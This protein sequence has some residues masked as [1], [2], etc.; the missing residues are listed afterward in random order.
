MKYGT[1]SIQKGRNMRS[2]A[3]KMSHGITVGTPEA[4][5]GANYTLRTLFRGSIWIHF[6]CKNRST[7]INEITMKNK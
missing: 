5:Q 6:G 7:S 4:S 3:I 1:K 2:E